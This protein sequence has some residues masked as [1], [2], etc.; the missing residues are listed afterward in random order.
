MDIQLLDTPS[1]N[2]LIGMHWHDC[3]CPQAIPK[4]NKE[5]PTYFLIEEIVL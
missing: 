1:L 3:M 5:N 4:Q 2:W